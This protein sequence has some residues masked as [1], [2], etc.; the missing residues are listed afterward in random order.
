MSVDEKFLYV[1]E[2][3]VTAGAIIGSLEI[4]EGI[5]VRDA[6]GEVLNGTKKR[7]G[8]GATIVLE[9]RTGVIKTLVIILRGDLD[10]DGTVTEQDANRI[11]T[12]SNGM[13]VSD[14]NLDLPAGDMN[15][16]G[17]LSSADAYLAHLRAL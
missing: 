8:T 16:D 2:T 6:D 11:L 1:G 3:S 4:Q 5:T 15:G 9:G 7:V 12:I 17:K 10:G 13:T 14:S